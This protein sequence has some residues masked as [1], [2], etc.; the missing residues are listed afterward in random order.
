MKE[1]V[2]DLVPYDKSLSGFAMSLRSQEMMIKHNPLDR[3]DIDKLNSI[4][5]KE[6]SE[7]SDFEKNNNYRWFIKISDEVVANVS[8]KN[9]NRMIL[10]ADIGYAVDE[11]HY[12]KGIATQSVKKVLQLTFDNSPLRKII[13][14][15]HID[16]IASCRVLEKLGFVKEGLLREHYIINDK[17]VDEAVYGLLRNEWEEI[18]QS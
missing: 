17:P 10:T 9:V 12:G 18:C 1:L 2:I 16:N 7:W 11:N 14:Y 4:L 3:V 15:V 5:S 8:I 13:A 6:S